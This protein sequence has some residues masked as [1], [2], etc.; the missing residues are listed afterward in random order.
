MNTLPM[1]ESKEQFYRYTGDPDQICSIKK[2]ELKSGKA[3]GVM[4]FDVKNGSGLEFTVLP[5]RCLDISSLSF[6]GVNCSYLSK[7]GITAPNYN[8][9]ESNF[10]RSFYAG[11]LTTC[12]LRNVG[13]ACKDSGESFG[14]HGRIS[15]IPAEDISVTTNWIND[16]PEMTISGKIKEASFFGENLLLE[17]KIT[18]RFGENR[19]KISNTI[20]NLG[21]RPEI[22]ML[23]LH[24][25]IGY[26]LLDSN[27][28]FLSSSKKVTPRDAEAKKGID[29]YAQFQPPTKNY[30]EQVFYHELNEDNNGN[31]IVALINSKLEIGFSLHFNKRQFSHYTHWKQ[32]GEGEYVLGMEPC[33]CYVGGRL[34]PRNKGVL[35]NILPFEKKHFEVTVDLHS[36]IEQLQALENS[37]DNINTMYP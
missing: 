22:L 5:D 30:A 19:I 20:E 17:R 31:T 26:P 24:F 1:L 13:N 35:T 37:I 32:M 9:N 6:N 33:N 23:L 21:F 3:N 29:E 2:Y 4:A 25:N 36:G 10:F 12:G 15:N 11:F 27:S 28:R 8:E 34:D 16:V 14:I 7:A 18:C